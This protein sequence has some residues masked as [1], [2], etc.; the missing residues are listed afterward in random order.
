M[1][2]TLKQLNTT[3]QLL[4]RQLASAASQ[5]TALN[6]SF[7]PLQQSFSSVLAPLGALQALAEDVSAPD[8]DPASI[9]QDLS[10]LSSRD[11]FPS[12]ALV[13]NVTT[14][15]AL[16]STL[17]KL[18]AGAMDGT[19]NDPARDQLTAKLGNV[20]DQLQALPNAT[21]LTDRLLRLQGL[22][23]Q[24]TSDGVLNSLASALRAASGSVGAMPPLSTL[25]ATVASI[26]RLI[27]AADLDGADAAVA[28]INRTVHRFPDHQVVTH[29]LQRILSITDAVPCLAD[30]VAE[31]TAV[32]SS[33]FLL[34][35]SA[36]G[37]PALLTDLNDTI[38]DKLPLID[39][40]NATL[41]DVIQTL[42]CVPLRAVLLPSSP[43][44]WVSWGR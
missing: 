38:S 40:F 7:G 43:R 36:D 41:N 21:A 20:R 18:I 24:A 2:S 30:I 16:P 14:N 3:V 33:L 32:N 4:P 13:A 44:R 23:S 26:A 12:P 34:P 11:S 29:Q 6:S 8:A 42:T 17:A 22:V 35:A 15:A 9:A 1:D 5:L 19:A 28:A 10:D 31:L 27:G 37:L 39:D 25:N